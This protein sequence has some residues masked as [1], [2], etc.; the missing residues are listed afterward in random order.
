M[1]VFAQGSAPPGGINLKLSPRRDS[2]LRELA[3]MYVKYID[4]LAKALRLAC[5]VIAEQ[6]LTKQLQ[7]CT[8]LFLF[9]GKQK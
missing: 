7:V 5:T 2:D 4:A 8:E 6:I 9:W 3:T 1:F